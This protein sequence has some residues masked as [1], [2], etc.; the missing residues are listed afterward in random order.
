MDQWVAGGS[1][2]LRERLREKTVELIERHESEPLPDGVRE[3]IA[4]ILASHQYE[5]GHSDGTPSTLKGLF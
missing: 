2:R 1:K 4:Y 3:E 5:K